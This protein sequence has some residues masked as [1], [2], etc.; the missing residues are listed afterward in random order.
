MAPEA[1]SD[2]GAKKLVPIGQVQHMSLRVPQFTKLLVATFGYIFP[3][4]RVFSA[5]NLIHALQST[6]TKSQSNGHSQELIG[7]R[8]EEMVERRRLA[9]CRRTTRLPAE[10]LESGAAFMA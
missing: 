4:L 5:Q 6:T 2:Q 8:V 7:I 3:R 9:V 10:S 1:R